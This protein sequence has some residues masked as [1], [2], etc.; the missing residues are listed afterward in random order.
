MSGQHD[1]FLERLKNS[2]RAVFVIAQMQH[3]KGH[4][5][6]IP[7]TRFAPTA[8]EADQY[9]DDG[10]LI[11]DGERIEIKHRDIDF[12]SRADWPYRD[13]FV[14]NVAAVERAGDE[15]TAYMVVSKDYSHVA[16]IPRSTKD[17]WYTVEVLAKNTGNVERNYSCP[18]DYV[19]FEPT[20]GGAI[21]LTKP[22][23]VEKWRELFRA[24]DHHKA[25]HPTIPV[26]RWR[27]FLRDVSGFMRSPDPAQWSWAEV[28]LDVGWDD[29]TLFAL[30]RQRPWQRL[31]RMGALWM[32]RTSIPRLW[33]CRGRWANDRQLRER[34]DR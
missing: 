22:S 12:T 17:Y 7:K 29:Y 3:A 24:M 9:L 15:V 11:V 30:D 19:V 21:V 18:I 4:T 32:L 10:D 26:A 16:T 1:R 5:V 27:Q 14:S 28:A 31:D 20:A 34:L 13:M 2:S 23:R 8:A 6:E 25:P 33:F